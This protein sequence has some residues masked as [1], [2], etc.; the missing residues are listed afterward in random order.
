MSWLRVTLSLEIPY[1]L[2]APYGKSTYN[3][4]SSFVVAI[5]RGALQV[6]VATC[7]GGR[8]TQVN[9]KLYFSF[10]ILTQ[11]SNGFP[12]GSGSAIVSFFFGLGTTF[13]PPNNDANVLGHCLTSRMAKAY[14]HRPIL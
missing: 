9:S 3:P 14:I 10:N 4:C 6:V 1:F 11:V 12:Y 13:V 2:N 8:D 7:H 5:R